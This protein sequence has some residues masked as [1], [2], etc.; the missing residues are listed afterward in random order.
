M[1]HHD[2]KHQLIQKTITI[3]IRCTKTLITLYFPIKMKKEVSNIFH[4]VCSNGRGSL[5]ILKINYISEFFMFQGRKWFRNFES[6]L[7]SFCEYFLIL[8]R[9]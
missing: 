1:V 9:I 5:S 6:I 8:W 2:D 4:I 7:Q 3:I